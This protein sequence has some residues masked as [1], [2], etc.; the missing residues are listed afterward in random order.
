MKRE[1][2]KLKL[3][4]RNKSLLLEKRD[5]N[6]R[7]LEKRGNSCRINIVVVEAEN[8]RIE[9]III[10]ATMVEAST[11]E[12]ILTLMREMRRIKMDTV[13]EEDKKEEEDI[14]E[15][16]KVA[17]EEE[18]VTDIRERKSTIVMQTKT[19]KMSKTIIRF[20]VIKMR[21]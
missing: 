19:R 1:P 3:L 6:K 18:E 10:K 20:G 4:E 12:E 8:S 7:S 11:R 16:I 9:I 14:K 13:E 17:M 15:E 21:K 2:L 5:N